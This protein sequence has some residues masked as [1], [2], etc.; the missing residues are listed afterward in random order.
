[1]PT[2]TPPRVA[3]ILNGRLRQYDAADLFYKRPADQ[4]V[5]RFFGGQ[6]FVPG[7]SEGG[8]FRSALGP[9]RLPGDARSGPGTLTFRPEAVRIGAAGENTITARLLDRIYLGTQT[10]LRMAVGDI[11]IEA[12]L[13]PDLVEGLAVGADVPLTL[14]RQTLWV[15]Q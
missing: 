12:V 11:L 8:V 4:D 13:S 5:A 3:L 15:L 6:N 14:P 9:L 10:R 1:M 7:V 2:D